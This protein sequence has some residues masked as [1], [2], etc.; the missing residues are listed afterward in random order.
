[1]NA[2]IV[3]FDPAL[4]ALAGDATSTALKSFGR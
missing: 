3:I 4:A 1:M 2:A